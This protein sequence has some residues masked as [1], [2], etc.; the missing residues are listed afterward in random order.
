MDGVEGAI[1]NKVYRDVRSG[2]VHIEDAKSFAEYADITI[3]NIKSLYLPL[4]DILQEPSEIDLVPKIK[5][6]LEVHCVRREF[7]IDWNR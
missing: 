7:T 1:K 2:K 4:D 5:S 6:V 3:R